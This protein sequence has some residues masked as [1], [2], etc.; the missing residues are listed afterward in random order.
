MGIGKAAVYKHIP[1]YFPHDVGAVGGLVECSAASGASSSPPM[2]A[3]SQRWTGFPSS[4]FFVLFLL[5]VACS[6]WMHWTVVGCCTRSARA[7][8][9]LESHRSR[10]RLPPEPP[11][12]LRGT[13]M[14]NVA[15]ARRGSE[16]LQSWD[17]ENEE[18]WDKRLAWT[19]L[20]ITTFTLTLCFASWFLA[21][22]IAPKLT[23]LGF[24][25]TQSQLYWLTSMPGLAGGLMRLVWMVLPPIMGTARWSP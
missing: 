17:P 5:T 11:V 22:A 9:H 10:R 1:E 20:W 13:R 24:D 6:V 14:S 15:E 19:T 25:F 21:S 7:G 8:E 16:W 3:Y 2:F 23:N 12:S 18:T 4:T